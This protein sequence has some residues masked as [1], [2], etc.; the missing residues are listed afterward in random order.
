M[1]LISRF[2]HPTLL[3]TAALVL[4]SFTACTSSAPLFFRAVPP[5]ARTCQ[6]SWQSTPRA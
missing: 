5:L 6:A 4:T 3:S 2:R 1:R